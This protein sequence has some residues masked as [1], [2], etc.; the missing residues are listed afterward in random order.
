[1]DV[2]ERT[3][4]PVE[5]IVPAMETTL[6]ETRATDDTTVTKGP[7]SRQNEVCQA[8]FQGT[9]SHSHSSSRGPDREGDLVIFWPQHFHLCRCHTSVPTELRHSLSVGVQLPDLKWFYP[10]GPWAESQSWSKDIFAI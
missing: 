1:M 10:P 8:T 9:S 4:E 7:L 3:F 5:P 6:Y 2:Y